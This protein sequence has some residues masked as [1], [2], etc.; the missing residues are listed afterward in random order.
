MILLAVQQVLDKNKNLDL[1]ETALIIATTKGNIN[2]LKKNGAFLE[3]R[4]KLSELGKV[5]AN[6]FGFTQTP[7]L[8]PTPVFRVA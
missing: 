7:L 8:F 3:T 4:L 2:L 6:F 1:T 5:I